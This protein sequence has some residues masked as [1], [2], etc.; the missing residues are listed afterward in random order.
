MDRIIEIVENYISGGLT[1]WNIFR[2]IIDLY[3]LFIIFMY[4]ARFI[5]SNSRLLK[6]FK[7][8]FLFLIFYITSELLNLEFSNII[9]GYIFTFGILIFIIL[10]SNE[11]KQ[12][13]VEN[14]KKL[15]TKDLDEFNQ[16]ELI[17][18]IS[19]SV[20][21]LSRRRIGALITFEKNQRLTEYIEK[22]IQL[23]SVISTELLTS[24]FVPTTP[25]HDGAVIIRGNRIMCAGAYYPSAE[26]YEIPKTFGSR[27]R[28]AIGI[29]ERTDALTL[30][31]SEETGKISVTIDGIIDTNI[32]ID[33]IKNYLE[34]H[35][36]N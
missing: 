32:S 4:L 13:I 28:A 34:K 14:K 19:E 31:V 12:E 17:N 30:V 29:S 18:T 24:I 9:Y 20:E 27:H 33:E 35:L 7:V 10:F 1:F 2:L 22:A 26:K 5:I 11:I 25:L 16:G 36:N 8:I 15:K 21:Y 23:D 6:S 3:L